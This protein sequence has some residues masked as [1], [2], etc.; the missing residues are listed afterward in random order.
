MAAQS[1]VK[2]KPSDFIFGKMI[3][4]GSFSNVR[5]WLFSKMFYIRNRRRTKSAFSC[6]I[7]MQFWLRP[8]M[9]TTALWC[10]L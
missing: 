10:N 5:Q 7:M 2:K 9:K 8:C 6:S 3:G 1:Q 4:E